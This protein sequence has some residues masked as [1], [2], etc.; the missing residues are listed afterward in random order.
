MILDEHGRWITM[1]EKI[2]KESFFLENLEA[3]KVL[4]DGQWLPIHEAVSQFSQK[5]DTNQVKTVNDS[6]NNKDYENIPFPPETVVVESLEND[7]PP[8]T[9]AISI[10]EYT[11]NKTDKPKSDSLSSISNSIITEET[12]AFNPDSQ[13]NKHVYKT[14]DYQTSIIFNSKKLK[15]K[16]RK[17]KLFFCLFTV[18]LFAAIAAIFIYY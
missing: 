4:Y 18:I 8:E 10:E 12:I 5:S 15:N 6:N 1:A 11:N 14:T 7:F 16:K 17:G 2:K 13:F 3:G 9:T